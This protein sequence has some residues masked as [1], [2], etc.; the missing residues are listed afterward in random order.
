MK[1]KLAD[2][3][4]TRAS[5]ISWSTNEKKIAFSHTTNSG[6]ELWLLMSLPQSDSTYRRQSQS[7]ETLLAGIATTKHFSKN[8]A[9]KQSCFTRKKN[10]PTGPIV[11]NATGTI[12]QTGPIKIY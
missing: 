10:L 11:S 3:L 5:T 7:L 6:V 9:K 12:S 4:L 1:F 8:A 2:Y